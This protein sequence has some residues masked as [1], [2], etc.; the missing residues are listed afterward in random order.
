MSASI[1]VQTGS[2][3]AFVSEHLLTQID[4]GGGGP[5]QANRGLRWDEQ[6]LCR[7]RHSCVINPVYPQDGRCNVQS[8]YMKT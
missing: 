4:L 1:D 7:D 2:Y 5:S 3:F 8:R 6:M